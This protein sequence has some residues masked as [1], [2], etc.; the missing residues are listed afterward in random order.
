MQDVNE[1][2]ISNIVS[3]A[4]STNYTPDDELL[5]NERAAYESDTFEFGQ[6]PMHAPSKQFC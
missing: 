2:S 5:E 1:T 6:I 4:Q 3:Q